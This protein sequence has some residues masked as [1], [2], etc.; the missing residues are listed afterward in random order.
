MENKN[1]NS[2]IL[3]LNDLIDCIEKN[4]SKKF[5]SL[6]GAIH[7]NF[8]NGQELKDE[9]I[10]I[11]PYQYQE[12]IHQ[13][14]VPLKNAAAFCSDEIIGAWGNVSRDNAIKNLKELILCYDEQDS[15][16]NNIS[17]NTFV[18]DL[19]EIL[20]RLHRNHLYLDASENARNDY[21]RD[22]LLSKNYFVKDQ[23]RQGESENGKD[24]GELDL[25]ICENSKQ[26]DI[27]IE[28]FN[29]SACDTTKIKSHY[30]KIFGYDK[31]GN[32]LN[33][34]LIYANVRDVS[35]FSEKY[36][37]YFETYNGDFHCSSIDFEKY[38][39]ANIKVLSSKH[40]LNEKDT[41]EIKHI[42]ILFSKKE[43]R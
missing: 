26:K 4:D 41:I 42:I 11:V 38:P 22:N 5:M 3:L 8:C 10:Q 23:S 29:L 9:V 7:Y 16:E 30:E 34:F 24:S 17:N 18:K 32:P 37:S 31:S 2:K 36:K 27:V 19:L 1:Y 28:G 40:K 6:R 14:L 25:F 15:K 13:T 21:V 35:Q 12:A 39:Y 20:E 43:Q 33:I